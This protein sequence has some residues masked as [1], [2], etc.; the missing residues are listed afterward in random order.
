MT[1]VISFS[2][3]EELQTEDAEHTLKPDFVPQFS[4][5]WCLFVETDWVV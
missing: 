1:W 5:I 4:W 2:E 3:S